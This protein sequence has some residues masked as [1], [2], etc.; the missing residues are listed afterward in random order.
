MSLRHYNVKGFISWLSILCANCV[1]GKKHLS[2]L[3]LECPWHESLIVGSATPHGYITT[4][5]FASGSYAHNWTHQICL[6]IA[7]EQGILHVYQYIIISTGSY[8]YKYAGWLSTFKIQK[9]KHRFI[10]F[11]KIN[12]LSLQIALSLLL[13]QTKPPAQNFTLF[14]QI[15]KSMSEQ[16]KHNKYT[17]PFFFL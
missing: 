6:L 1:F 11:L 3:W 5:C 9:K 14:G 7:V 17:F 10:I 16:F 12:N 13:L 8:E 4:K 2:Q 15:Q